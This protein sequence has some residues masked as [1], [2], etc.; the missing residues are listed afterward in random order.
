MKKRLFLGVA[1]ALVAIL[2]LSCNK[3]RFDF[4][5]LET[6][7]GS[8][9]WKLP[10]G[11]VS[12][13]LGDVLKQLGENDLISYDEDG[14][15]QIHYSFKLNDI[16]KGSS[17]LS[18][19][20]MNFSSEIRFANP[21]PGYHL[22]DPIDTVYRFQQSIELDAD[23]A[24]LETAVIKTCTMLSTI[25]GNLGNVSRVEISSSDITMPNG[26]S[27]KGQFRN[28]AITGNG[29][30]TFANGDKY[31]GT[32]SNGL[33]EGKGV[34][35]WADGSVYDGEWK[36]NRREGTGRMVWANGDSY[37]GEWL[38][39]KPWG[40]GSM[41]LAD[42]T[43]FR[44]TFVDGLVDGKGEVVESDGTRLEGM[45]KEGFRSGTFVVKDKSGKQIRTIVY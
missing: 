25:Q 45:F 2:M 29:E 33:A 19:G 37:Y 16:L 30:Y 5:N 43:K 26:D 41:S 21:F 42:G 22:P 31:K 15:L 3:N 20:T 24:V 13:T 40:E 38:E 1:L 36:D 6:V 4:D 10:I 9:Q 39:D 34:F 18:L 32:L 14:N 35:T 28:G 27:Y 17:F 23:S 44:G 12:T 7:E 11:N 8:G